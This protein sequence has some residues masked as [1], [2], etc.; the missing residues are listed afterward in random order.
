[1]KDNINLIVGK[2]NAELHIKINHVESAFRINVN[3]KSDALFVTDNGGFGG[4]SQA[5]AMQ[6]LNYNFRFEGNVSVCASSDDHLIKSCRLI[7]WMT[8]DK[9]PAVFATKVISSYNESRQL[10][11]EI[12]SI[13]DHLKGTF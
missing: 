7:S 13:V 11:F 10:V 12:L 9:H 6:I 4:Y 5:A 2:M 8:N 3:H 1:M